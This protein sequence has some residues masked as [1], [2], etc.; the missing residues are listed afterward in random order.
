MVF[1]SPEG[2]SI[3]VN[4]TNRETHYNG[5]FLPQGVIHVTREKLIYEGVYYEKL[6]LTNYYYSILNI[7]IFF[8]FDSDFKDIFEIRFMLL[9]KTEHGIYPYAGIPWFN[10]IFGRDGLIVG[11]QTLWWNPEI[12]RGVLMNLAKL[13]AEEMIPEADAQPGK[14]LHELR[15]GELVEIG[16]IPFKKYYGSVDSTPLF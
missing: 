12:A 9:T 10:T 14:I 2:I 11:L 7:P 13:Q 15:Y 8:K 16:E 3:E 1:F 4:I 6:I 5:L